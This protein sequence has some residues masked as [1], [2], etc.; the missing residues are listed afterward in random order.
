MAS[1]GEYPNQIFAH[2]YLCLQ[3][4]ENLLYAL[5]F[6]DLFHGQGL[7]NLEDIATKRYPPYNFPQVEGTPTTGYTLAVLV[8]SLLRRISL[9]SVTPYG[10]SLNTLQR[11]AEKV[12]RGDG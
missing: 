1:K 12:T 10:M 7:I 4:F 9:R 6:L 11:A 2:V 3:S 8:S 5:V